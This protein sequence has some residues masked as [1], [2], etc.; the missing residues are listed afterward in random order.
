[1]G[2]NVLEKIGVSAYKISSMDCTNLYLLDKV[3]E[4]KKP[5]FISTGKATLEEIS[6]RTN[7]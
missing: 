2:G 3:A 7:F 6:E 1:M 4:T 5:I